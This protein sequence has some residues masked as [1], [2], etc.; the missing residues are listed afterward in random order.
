MMN[1]ELKV[2]DKI[3]LYYMDGEVGNS[4]S[5]GTNGIVT[6][7]VSDPFEKNEKIIYVKWDDGST[8]SLLSATDS[9]KKVKNNLVKEESKLIDPEIDPY[10]SWIERN[11]TIKKSFNISYLMEFLLTLK[12][13]GI[14]NMYGASPLLY[15]GKEHI[16]RYYGEN[17]EDDESFQKLIEDADKA[18]NV[19]IS[20]LLKWME[21]KDLDTSD[22]SQ[23]N[24]YAKKLS[25]SLLK[26]YVLFHG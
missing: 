15:S 23:V 14:V 17:R 2:G 25:Q 5:P 13:S 19:F 7:I 21:I 12:E 4:P 16:Q 11:I 1:P 6:K 10:A 20:G 22:L 26:Y 3:I 9:W 18:K 8:L 24:S